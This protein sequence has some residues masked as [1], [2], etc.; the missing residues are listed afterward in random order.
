MKISTNN[1]TI[2]QIERLHEKGYIISLDA[3]EEY[4]EVYKPEPQLEKEAV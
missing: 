2:A 1:L 4:A 3:D